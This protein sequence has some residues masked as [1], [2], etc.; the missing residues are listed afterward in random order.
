MMLADVQNIVIEGV[1]VLRLILEVIAACVLAAGVIISLFRFA[2]NL[3][4]FDIDKF[5]ETR[6]A[7]ASYLALAL[8]FELGAD[9]LSTAISPSWDQIGKLGAIAVIRTGLNYFLLRELREAKI[10]SKGVRV[11]GSG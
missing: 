11:L 4:S 3:T 6:L 2:R 1:G 8:E 9:I 5:S 7:L 10:T